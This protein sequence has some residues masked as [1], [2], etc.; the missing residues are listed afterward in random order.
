[1]ILLTSCW[2]CFRQTLNIF[3][4]AKA[5]DMLS[6]FKKKSKLEKLKER[7]TSLMRKSFKIALKNPDKCEYFHSQ[8][9]EIFEKIKFL[10]LQSN[11]EK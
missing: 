7:Y 4:P 10:S 9:D 2:Q 1:M 3:V 5:I 11:E 8:A 6:R